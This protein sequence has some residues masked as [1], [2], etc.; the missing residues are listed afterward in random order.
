MV[1]FSCGVPGSDAHVTPVEQPA[2]GAAALMLEAQLAD[3]LRVGQAVLTGD[4]RDAIAAPEPQ[5]VPSSTMV[6]PG[7]NEGRVLDD[8]ASEL[9]LIIRAYRRPTA[10]VRA[11]CVPRKPIA[12]LR[13]EIHSWGGSPGAVLPV[14]RHRR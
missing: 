4:G 10:R 12:P 14:P 13:R 7:G 6:M 2:A 9:S 11:N 1:T 3:D 5:L 8:G